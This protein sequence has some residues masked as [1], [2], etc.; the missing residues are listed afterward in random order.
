MISTKVCTVT[1]VTEKDLDIRA[2]LN[3]FD[4]QEVNLTILMDEVKYQ[5]RNRERLNLMNLNHMRHD[6][7]MVG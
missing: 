6:S 5:W 2:Y 4:K 1:M 3:S 7:N